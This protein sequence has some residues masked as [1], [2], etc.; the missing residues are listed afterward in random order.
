MSH[1]EDEALL[2]AVAKGDQSALRILYDRY[3][4]T[5]H[6]F[7]LRR[8]QEPAL[9]QEVVNDS[10]LQVWSAAARFE[11]RSSVKTWLLSIAKFKAIDALRSQSSQH[12]H[13]T[14]SA[15]HELELMRMP[16]DTQ[17]EPE[18]QMHALQ[19]SHHL[20]ACF[21]A[22]PIDQRESMHLAY[23]EGMS[24]LEISDVLQ[25]P[26]GT[27]G[28]RIHHAKAKLKAC[29]SRRLNAGKEGAK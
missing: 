29:L 9:A 22:L 19:Q 15:D 25:I 23:V 6:A 28:T 20:A 24:T 3:A 1:K 18:Q 17:L 14:P 10:F 27:V 13:E 7:V 5:V 26:S 21:E 16:A 2:Q 8:L 12:A 4:H 11:N